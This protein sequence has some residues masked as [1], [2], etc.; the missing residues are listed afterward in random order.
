MCNKNKLNR[1]KRRKLSALSIYTETIKAVFSCLLLI[2]NILFKKQTTDFEIYLH[3]NRL[4]NTKNL[5][6]ELFFA[7]LQLKRYQ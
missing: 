3:R 7:P 2:Q 1:Q 4:F 6:P 5:I